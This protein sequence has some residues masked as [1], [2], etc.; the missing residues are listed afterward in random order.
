VKKTLMIDAPNLM[1]D[2]EWM[3]SRK[4][5]RRENPAKERLTTK[6]IEQLI[7]SL[8]GIVGVIV[9]LALLAWSST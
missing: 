3:E 8:F 4:R 6:D 2:W 9:V 7:S 1:N 5:E